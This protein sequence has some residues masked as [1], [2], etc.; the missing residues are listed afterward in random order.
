MSKMVFND[1]DMTFSAAERQRAAILIVEPDNQERHNFRQT[2]KA[3]GYGNIGDAPNHSTALERMGER[4]F[5]HVLFDAKKSTMPP[6]EFLTK[7]FELDDSIVAMPSSAN[8]NVD[9]V[10][11]LLVLGAKGYVCKPFTVDTLDMAI[12]QATKGEPMADA[13]LKAKDRNEALVAIMMSSLDKAATIMRQANQFE[14]AKREIP[15]AIARLKRSA[16][17]AKTFAKDGEEGLLLAMETFCIERSKGPASKLGRLRKRLSS[18]RGPED[19]DQA[20]A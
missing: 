13:V 19:E 16:E 17:L 20:N 8:P 11:G 4:K 15:K 6:S 18:N 9:D 7:I 5:T 2:L 10:F 14:T 1:G 12:I 3:L